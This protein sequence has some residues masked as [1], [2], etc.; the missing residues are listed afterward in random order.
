MRT[1]TVVK[2]VTTQKNSSASSKPVPIK[3]EGHAFVPMQHYFNKLWSEFVNAPNL[4]N[5]WRSTGLAGK[6]SI[7]EPALDVSETEKA[8][9]IH[10]ELPGIDEKDVEVTISNDYLVIKGMKN[11]ELSEEGENFIRCE[12]SRGSFQR[13]VALPEN[14]N[15]DRANAIFK[16]G[17]L[18]VE[19]PKLVGTAKEAHKLEIQHAA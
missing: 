1:A 17:M 5:M 13:S 8:F 2:N 6:L 12:C 7:V 9:R 11:Y 16:N 19:L 14:I 10:V 3:R 15:T 4:L 18:T